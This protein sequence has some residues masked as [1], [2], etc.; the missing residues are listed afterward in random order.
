MGSAKS[1]RNVS[2]GYIVPIPSFSKP[3]ELK[4]KKESE[5]EELSCFGTELT[6]YQS[7]VC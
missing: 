3:T 5:N 6:Y 2:D 1:A 4:K 7:P